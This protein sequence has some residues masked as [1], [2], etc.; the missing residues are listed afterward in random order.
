[1]IRGALI[2]CRGNGGFGDALEGTS[3]HSQWHE[4]WLVLGFIVSNCTS[5]HSLS[6][7]YLF[8]YGRKPYLSDCALISGKA[9]RAPDDSLGG[10]LSPSQ[11][12]G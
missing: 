3:G 10:G 1:M 2:R 8:L 5:E 4:K 7:S 6:F 9:L 11:G 12:K